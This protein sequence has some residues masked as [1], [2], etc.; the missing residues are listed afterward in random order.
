MKVIPRLGSRLILLKVENCLVYIIFIFERNSLLRSSAWVRWLIR[1]TLPPTV[2]IHARPE[3]AAP[4]HHTG[5]WNPKNVF[6]FIPKLS[7][8]QGSTPGFHCGDFQACNY[9]LVRS[10][11]HRRTCLL[12]GERVGNGVWESASA[13]Y[14][15]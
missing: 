4:W 2:S 1:L 15:E 13:E 5:I 14:H 12:L 6:A 7:F 10:H 9:S 8:T 11:R 3:Q